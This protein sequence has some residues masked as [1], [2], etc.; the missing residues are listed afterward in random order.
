MG[1]FKSKGHLLKR[2]QVEVG[3]ATSQG[4]S[5]HHDEAVLMEGRSTRRCLVL[6]LG[7]CRTEE[8]KTALLPSTPLSSWATRRS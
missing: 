4:S 3:Q 6:C 5:M 2:R 1:S 7:T 8:N